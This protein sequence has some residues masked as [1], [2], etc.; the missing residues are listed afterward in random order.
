[1]TK[2][3]WKSDFL[4]LKSRSGFSPRFSIFV[5]FK[6]Q[7]GLKVLT[8]KETRKM[9]ICSD[10]RPVWTCN[11]LTICVISVI[12]CVNPI[13]I[14]TKPDSPE[15]GGYR[16]RQ[17]RMLLGCFVYYAQWLKSHQ[18]FRKNK[19]ISSIQDFWGFLTKKYIVF[20]MN[21]LVEYFFYCFTLLEIN[22]TYTHLNLKKFFT[23]GIIHKWCPI[24][25]SH[26]WPPLPPL[27]RF[28]PYKIQFF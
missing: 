7:A 18:I 13:E 2:I 10:S 25:L 11:N 20:C 14:T 28:L 23:L 5:G 19:N 3:P 4:G 22:D 16:A 1:M 24:Y 27:I 26:F 15:A 9:K 17:R 21:R 6:P 12:F 8:V